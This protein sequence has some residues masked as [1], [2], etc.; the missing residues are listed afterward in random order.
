VT[1][2]GNRSRVRLASP[3]M[4]AARAPACPELADRPVVV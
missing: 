4:R 1:L 2:I 3:I